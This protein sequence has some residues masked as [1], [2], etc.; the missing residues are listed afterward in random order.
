MEFAIRNSQLFFFF[1]K[2]LG[3]QDIPNSIFTN[4]QSEYHILLMQ[5]NLIRVIPQELG[6]L[7]HLTVIHL[8]HNE[9]EGP[10]PVS[11]CTIKTLTYL[12][13]GKN[14]ISEI[15][16][17]IGN[18]VNL[19]LLALCQN[20]IKQLPSCKYFKKKNKIYSIYFILCNYFIFYFKVLFLFIFQFILF[21]FSVYFILFFVF[22]SIQF[23]FFIF[24]LF[25][26]FN[27]ILIF[28]FIF[29]Y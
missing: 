6:S 18:L 16:N 19:E 17:E 15:P 4:Q 28:Y 11:I 9:M 25:L 5:N 23:I 22:K 1:S 26:F 29:F 12:N 13:L 3:I 10:L 14:K 2:G 27:F 21:Y 7:K 24:I 20:Q 8:A